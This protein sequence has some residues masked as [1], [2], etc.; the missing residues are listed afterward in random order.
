MFVPTIE[1]SSKIINFKCLYFTLNTCNLS[2]NKKSLPYLN[3]LKN[4]ETI[5]IPLILYAALPV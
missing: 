2:A 1:I 3:F 4:A 5:V